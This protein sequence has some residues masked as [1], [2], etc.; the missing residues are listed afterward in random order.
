MKAL[1]VCDFT[2][3]LKK[4]IHLTENTCGCQKKRY[5]LLMVLVRAFKYFIVTENSSFK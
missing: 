5:G 4:I 1:S 3:S 2:F